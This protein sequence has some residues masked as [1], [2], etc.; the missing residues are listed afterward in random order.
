MNLFVKI[1]ATLF[2]LAVIGALLFATLKEDDQSTVSTSGDAITK[3]SIKWELMRHRD[4]RTGEIPEN[5]RSLE[6]EFART[7]P[8]SPSRMKY[9]HDSPLSQTWVQRGPYYTGGRSRAAALDVTDPTENTIIAGGVSGGMWRST[10]GGESWVKTTLPDQLHSVSCLTQDTRPGKEHIWYHG[11]GEFIGNSADLN[12]DGI[13]RSTDGGRSWHPLVSTTTDVPNSW[14]NKFE[15]IWRVV[16]NPA[17]PTDVDEIYAAT[18]LGAIFRSSDGGE[19]WTNVLGRFGNGNSYFTEIAVTSDGVFYATLSEASNRENG[20]PTRGIF[21]S[22]NGIDWT[23][24]TPNDFPENYRRIVIGI[25]PSDENQVYFL[26]ETPGFGQHTTNS[27]GDDIWDSFW[28]YTYKSGDGSGSGGQWEDRSLNLPDPELVRHQ[29]NP[30]YSYNLVCQ[31]K[32][33]DPNVVFIGGVNLYRCND[34]L[35]TPGEWTVVGGTCPDDNC[36][37]HY[38]YPNHHAD[39]HEIFFSKNNPDIMYTGSDGGIHKTL[40]C[41]AERVEWIN[42][43]NGFYTTQFYTCAIDHGAN[44]S[45]EIIGGLQDNGTLFQKTPDLKQPWREPGRGDGFN[46]A[47]ADSGKFYITSQ[48]SSQ[49][50]K[51]KIYKQ[52]FDENGQFV[53]KRRI[54]PIGGVDFIWNT[55]LAL[56]PNDNRIL[57]VAGGQQ[58]W[59]N[60]NI[61]DIPFDGST[62][63]VSINWD[64]LSHSRIDAGS[65]TA[66]GVSTL[67][68]NILYYGTSM[69]KIYRIDDANTGDPEVFDISSPQ[70]LT[71]SYVSSIAVDPTDGRKVLMSFSNYNLISIYYTEDAGESWTPVAG[72]LEAYPSGAGSGP[73]VHWVEAVSVTGKMMYFAGTSTGLYSTASLDGLF[74]V[75]QQEGAI[76]I[77]NNVI[78]MIDARSSDGFIAVGT[79]GVGVFSAFIDNIPQPPMAPDLVSPSNDVRGI[80]E[81]TELEWTEVDGAGYYHLQ[82]ALD[83]AFESIIYENN[84]ISETKFEAHNL[85]Q[86]LQNFYWRVRAK[87][88]GGP[89]DY[90]QVWSFR[91]AVAPPALSYPESGADSVE[92]SPT[93]MWEPSEGANAYHVLVSNNLFFSGIVID[94]VVDSQTNLTLNNLDADRKYFWKV[95]AINEDGE[96]I[97][98]EARNFRTQKAVSVFESLISENTI[99]IYPNPASVSASVRIISGESAAARLCIYDSR[100]MMVST[101]FEGYV[102]GGRQTVDLDLAGL[103]AGSYTLVYESGKTRAIRKLIVIK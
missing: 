41:M 59:R 32:P 12:G 49:Q 99:N 56:D 88:S 34:G 62:D 1:L 72:N 69:G 24:I 10:D 63:S 86:G 89:G 82:I 50:P 77:G 25:A 9:K 61:D 44:E 29:F 43:N 45:L 2:T 21:R 66:L 91:T 5:I 57:Y 30:Q 7:L 90:S 76:T 83:P 68:A 39:L 70:F 40:D 20:S 67:P 18:T 87:N 33:D 27:R 46:C 78:N 84:G 96:G 95:N 23:D 64:S 28:K 93:L 31:V 3:E 36:D 102:P 37:Y 38:R 60:R 17:A 16:V 73:A 103:P 15:F 81:S 22:T 19:S 74:T 101:A 4:P 98:S 79:H 11:T 80:L 52:I 92:V 42:L 51:I 8:G 55:P 54:D 65:V 94:T 100:G 97:Y 13:Y 47:I 6:L 58:I 35:A 53:D 75:W 48:N 26:A 71:G 14:D 85:P